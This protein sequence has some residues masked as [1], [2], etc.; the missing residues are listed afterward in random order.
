MTD[1][2]YDIYDLDPELF[3]QEFHPHRLSMIPEG[4]PFDE[5]TEEPVDF[6]LFDGPTDEEPEEN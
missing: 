6:D 1:S 3:D 5:D 2:I 4:G